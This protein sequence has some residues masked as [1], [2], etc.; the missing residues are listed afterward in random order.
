ML[1]NVFLVGTA[2]IF[3][4]YGALCFVK[5]GTLSGAAGITAVSATGTTELRAMYGGLQGAVGIL[6]IVAVF[7]PDLVDACLV[8][9]TTVTAG[10]LCART[11]GLVMD[12]DYTGYT[13]M[14]LVFESV[15][16]A[17]A[18]Y[19]LLTTQVSPRA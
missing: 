17:G 9:L 5:P 11:V 12:R 16:L 4:T 18:L 1:E 7:K 10:L 13:G 6:A 19:F 14:A 8:T 15:L 3:L 2:I